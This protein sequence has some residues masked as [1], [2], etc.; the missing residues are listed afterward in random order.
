MG[1]F[2]ANARWSSSVASSAAAAAGEEASGDVLGRVD[3]KSSRSDVLGRYPTE[4]VSKRPTASLGQR[5]VQRFR[6]LLRVSHRGRAWTREGH[7]GD[8]RL[9]LRL[10]LRLRL[11]KHFHGTVRGRSFLVVDD[12]GALVRDASAANDASTGIP[13]NAPP[14]APPSR[15]RDRTRVGRAGDPSRTRDDPSRTRDD[16][17]F[18]AAQ[19]RDDPRFPGEGGGTSRG[20]GPRRRRTSRGSGPRRR[21]TSRGSRPRRRRTSRGS[22]PRGRRRGEREVRGD[23]QGNVDRVVL[24]ARGKS[25][26]GRCASAEGRGRVVVRDERVHLVVVVVVR[27]GQSHHLGGAFASGRRVRRWGVAFDGDGRGRVEVVGHLEGRV[28]VRDGDVVRDR[29]GG[30]VAGIVQDE[31][32]AAG[33]D[34][35][36][37][38]RSRGGGRSRARE[39]RGRVGRGPAI[40]PAG[41]GARRG[42]G[43]RPGSAARGP[44]PRGRARGRV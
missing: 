41:G 11:V 4:V 27:G 40:F 39:G 31:H 28:A 13:S 37:R 7:S 36:G 26:G 25:A 9:L 8:V 38:S 12:L 17:R 5:A 15:E 3:A 19:T 44:G 24:D 16:P 14:T 32:L 6:A 29:V 20:S 30:G 35:N 34:R 1:S 22:R 21:R 2:P 33:R 18:P 23:V 10:L 43:A 42:R